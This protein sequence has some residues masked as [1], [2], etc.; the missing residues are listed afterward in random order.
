MK[1]SFIEKLDEEFGRRKKINDRYSL[2]AYAR[3]LGIEP[4]L[5]SKIL[6]RKIPLTLKML[7]RLS[8]LTGVTD[9]EYRQFAKELEREEGYGIKNI[10]NNE[11]RVCSDWYA[12]VMTEL[13]KLDG[14]KSDPKWMAKKLGITLQETKEMLEILLNLGILVRGGD[15]SIRASHEVGNGF[16]VVSEDPKAYIAASKK[17]WRNV[18]ERYY[19][20][21]DKLPSKSRAYHVMVTAI[22]SELIP[23]I[24]KEMQ[25]FVYELGTRMEK[26]SKKKDSIYE[27][28]FSIFPMTK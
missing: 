1:K 23:E 17:R 5:L 12:F 18:F 16:R 25:D 7:N 8:V 3:D 14:Y 15:D 9:A 19:E 11:L 2:R 21:V 27:I 26:K 6:R 28:D 20:T 22:D 24:N 10:T 4:S 13:P